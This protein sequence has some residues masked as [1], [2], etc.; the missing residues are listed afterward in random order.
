LTFPRVPL[1][2]VGRV[3]ALRTRWFTYMAFAHTAFS[4][5]QTFFLLTTPRYRPAVAAHPPRVLATIKLLQ[6]PAIIFEYFPFN[7]TGSLTPPPPYPRF[8]PLSPS[9][10]FKSFGRPPHLFLVSAPRTRSSPQYF[11]S[12]CRKSSSFFLLDGR[13]VVASPLPLLF[14]KGRMG[15]SR[16]APCPT[17]PQTSHPPP[18]PPPQKTP[19]KHNSRQKN[20]PPNN[21]N[22][23]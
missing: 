13:L 1:I 6:T 22:F 3:V 2:Y 9:Q 23:F 15:T 5:W 17:P 10:R 20:P 7:L 18:P 16:S 14:N 21:T 11:L 4:C 12:P 8:H 19:H